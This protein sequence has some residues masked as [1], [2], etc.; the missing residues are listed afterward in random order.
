MRVLTSICYKSFKRKKVMSSQTSKT[1]ICLE[2]T[3]KSEKLV[4]Q[5]KL[6]FKCLANKSNLINTSTGLKNHKTI[7]G[8]KV[9]GKSSVTMPFFP[10][11]GS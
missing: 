7:P 5:K 8:H 6:S 1:K 2:S 9:T 4:H 10:W 3:L 11:K